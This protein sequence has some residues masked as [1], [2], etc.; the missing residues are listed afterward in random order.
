MEIIRNGGG[1]PS[2][3]NIKTCGLNWPNGLKKRALGQ[4]ISV[5]ISVNIYICISLLCYIAMS[6]IDLTWNDLYIYI[7]IYIYRS[8]HV[9]SILDIAI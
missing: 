4:L 9:K 2:Q 1:L 3:Q 8:F 5:N 6:K 7:Y